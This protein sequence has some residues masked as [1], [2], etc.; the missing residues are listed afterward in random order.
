M[1]WQ[2]QK[3]TFKQ[4]VR[5]SLKSYLNGRVDAQIQTF[6]FKGLMSCGLNLSPEYSTVKNSIRYMYPCH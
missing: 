3:K 4:I 6:A 2:K 5:Q 1:G